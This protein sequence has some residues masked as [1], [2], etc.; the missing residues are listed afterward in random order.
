MGVTAVNYPSKRKSAVYLVGIGTGF[1]APQLFF[2]LISAALNSEMISSIAGNKAELLSYNNLEDK[3]PASIILYIGVVAGLAIG[4]YK[5]A[6]LVKQFF[7][8]VAIGFIIR[9]I[10]LGVGIDI[11]FTYETPTPAENLSNSS[12][13]VQTFE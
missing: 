13:T 11:P 6:G 8:G 4:A 9:M 3:K 10:A 2:N 5:V 12:Q 7:I 1:A